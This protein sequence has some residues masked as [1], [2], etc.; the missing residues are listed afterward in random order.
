MKCQ[1][2]EQHKKYNLDRQSAPHK[3]PPKQ[4]NK[5]NYT[6]TVKHIIPNKAIRTKIITILK[7]KITAMNSVK[8]FN[9]C[10]R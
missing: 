4:T 7:D 3:T 2:Q 6:Q 1:L 9:F 5:N 8:I 10:G